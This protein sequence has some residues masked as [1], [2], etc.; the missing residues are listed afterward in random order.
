VAEHAEKSA[1]VLRKNSR[2]RRLVDVE[3]V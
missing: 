3:F 1:L 2:V